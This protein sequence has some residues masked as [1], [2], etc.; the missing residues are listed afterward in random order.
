MKQKF[1]PTHKVKIFMNM[2]LEVMI[3]DNKVFYKYSGENK[4]KE[5]EIRENKFKIYDRAKES[6]FNIENFI[7]L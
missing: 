1:I 2:Y 7:K 4:V 6:V 5:T 3:N